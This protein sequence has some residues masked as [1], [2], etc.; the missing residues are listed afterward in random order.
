M[1]G[2]RLKQRIVIIVLLSLGLWLGGCSTYRPFIGKLM[3]TPSIYY[4][5]GLDPYTEN[6]PVSGDLILNIFYAT[7]RASTAVNDRQWFYSNRRGHILRLGEAKVKFDK[8]GASWADLRRYS[9][10][11]ER[12]E[13]LPIEVSDVNE[14]G[15]LSLEIPKVMKEY[16]E[17]KA[18]I[19]TRE[20]AEG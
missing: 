6:V 20:F 16:S 10:L 11:K 19:A 8:S 17:E 14:Y 15:P 18:S 7:D 1:P 5:T 3:S 9:V 2:Y 13:N 12:T 4:A